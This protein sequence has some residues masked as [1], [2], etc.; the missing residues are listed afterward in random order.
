M[1]LKDFHLVLKK[2]DKCFL[3]MFGNPEYILI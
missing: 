3:N 2:Y 1:V